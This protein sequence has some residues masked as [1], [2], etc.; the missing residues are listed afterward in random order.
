MKGDKI[1]RFT[2]L[3]AWQDGHQLALKVYRITKSFPTDERF[4]LVSQMRRCS[5]SIGSNIAEGFGRRSAGEKIRF[6]DIAVGSLFEL[7]N[8]LLLS[9]D[10]GLIN[11]N[12]FK[13]LFDTSQTTNKLLV[14][15]I[16]SIR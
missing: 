6:Y 10:L 15:L 7:Q 3:M 2:D 4:G 11:E 13:E 16:K 8:Q 5:V 1:E 14:G 9:K 12:E